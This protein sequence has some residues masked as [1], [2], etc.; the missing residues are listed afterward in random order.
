MTSIMALPTTNATGWSPSGC[1]VSY[2]ASPSMA[3]GGGALKITPTA[4]AA[5]SSITPNGTPYRVAV[6]PGAT[7]TG[8]SY[9][10]PTTS[11]AGTWE[12]ILYWYTSAGAAASTPTNT[13]TTATLTT[14]WNQLTVTAVAPAN[15]A[16]AG[17]LVKWLPPGGSATTDLFYAAQFSVA[18]GSSTVWTAPGASP[19]V[20]MTTSGLTAGG[21]KI[22]SVAPGAAGSDVVTVSQMTAAITAAA[23]R[24]G[25]AS[26]AFT[27]AIADG[28]S[29]SLTMTVAGCRRRRMVV[30]PGCARRVRRRAVSPTGS[31]PPRARSPW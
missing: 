21:Q 16:Y 8:I 10:Q 25:T 9:V 30:R 19:V 29:A 13:G 22:T 4:A 17:L 20:S 18:A 2:V 14:G 31:S 5:A 3:A 23:A 11:L 12:N 24:T 6:T 1:T 27:S 15:A 7:H 26:L 28:A